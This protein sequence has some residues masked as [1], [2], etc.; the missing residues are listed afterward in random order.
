MFFNRI[1]S[2][3]TLVRA[4]P[5][6]LFVLIT[7]GQG[8]LGLSPYWL[9]TLKTGLGAW[10]IWVMRPLVR[11]MKWNFSWAALGAGILVF[12]FWVG[13]DGFYP[14]L[15]SSSTPWN[16]HETFGQDSAAAWAFILVRLLGST[17]VVPPIEEVFYRSF[18]YRY[19]QQNN[20]M[21]R[22]LGGF[23]PL[24]FLITAV[25]FGVAHHEWLAGILC[26]FVYQGLV[27]W[28]NRLGDAIT[29][30]AITNFLLG[31]YIIWKGAWNFW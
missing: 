6:V 4:L 14:K 23:H 24:S 27:C 10:M 26:A 3:P 25:V 7:S 22:P 20:F 2:S 8:H 5:F 9:Y 21:A 28:K 12:L 30:H 1:K 15:F 11:E 19:I 16:P 18:L 13:L 17:L 31:L 29:A